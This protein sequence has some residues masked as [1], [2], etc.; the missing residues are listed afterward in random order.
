MHDVFISHASE[1]KD[2]VARPLAEHLRSYGLNVWYDEFSLRLGDSLRES[3]DNGLA[4]SRFGLVVLSRSFFS[5]RWPK[6]ELNGLFAIENV[7]D[8]K[9]IIPVWLDIT[10]AEIAQ[11]SPILADRFAVSMSLGLDVVLERVLDAIEPGARHKAAKGQVVTISPPS[12]RL[13]SGEWSVKTMVTVT[14]NGESPAYAVVI[15]IQIQGEGVMAES[16]EIDAEAQVPQVEE[17]IGNIIV[18]VDQIRLNCSTQDGHQL[19]MFILHT[20][21]ARSSCSFSIKGLVPVVSSAD[22]TLVDFDDKPRE[23]LVKDGKQVAVLFKTAENL[24]L[25]GIAMKM[26]KT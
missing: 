11:Y 14:N 12:V 19:V 1:D 16:L 13:H 18:S 22:I 20:V 21:L 24:K 6:A 4:D 8:E 7:V 26:R 25:N 23:L 17:S 10:Q 3:I 2:S 5:K 15:R 9:R